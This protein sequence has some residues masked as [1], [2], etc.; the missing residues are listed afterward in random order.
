MATYAIQRIY[1]ILCKNMTRFAKVFN[2]SKIQAIAQKKTLPLSLSIPPQENLRN[3]KKDSRK[4]NLPNILHNHKKKG[5]KFSNIPQNQS[6][7]AKKYFYT[8]TMPKYSLTN[9]LRATVLPSKVQ[10][11]RRLDRTF[12]LTLLTHSYYPLRR[13][14]THS[15]L[16]QRN[17]IPIEASDFTIVPSSFTIMATHV[18]NTKSDILVHAPTEGYKSY[19]YTTYNA[20]IMITEFILLFY[21]V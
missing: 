8:P 20:R 3:P 1:S 12:P 19:S 13:T 21:K 10:S 2:Q 11:V 5:R 15:P 17:S 9:G 16:K 6:F 14:H 7:T 4:Q 18:A